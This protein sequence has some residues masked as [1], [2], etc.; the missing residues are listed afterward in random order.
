MFGF[1]IFVCVWF[2][3]FVCVFFL[4]C[5]FV[6]DFLVVCFSFPNSGTVDL[7]NIYVF[8]WRQYLI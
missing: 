8:L 1:D 7:Q 5:G 6:L 4:V 3:I 2:R